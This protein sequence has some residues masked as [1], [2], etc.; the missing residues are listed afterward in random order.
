MLFIKLLTILASSSNWSL[1]NFDQYSGQYSSLVQPSHSVRKKL[2]FFIFHLFLCCCCF[3]CCYCHCLF[4]I[5]QFTWYYMWTMF[6][7]SSFSITGQKHIFNFC[8]K[9]CCKCWC[10]VYMVCSFSCRWSGKSLAAKLVYLLQ[11]LQKFSSNSHA[12][13]EVAKC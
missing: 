11:L 13:G 6:S 1:V 12:L 2:V 3:C 9:L 10:E 8:I 5:F 4:S 7:S